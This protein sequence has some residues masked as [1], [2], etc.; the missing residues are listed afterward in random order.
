MRKLTAQLGFKIT[1]KFAIR[2]QPG[3]L[4]SFPCLELIGMSCLGQDA[5]P[6]HFRLRA[7]IHSAVH[8]GHWR[9]FYVRT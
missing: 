1:L 7:D 3:V 2:T 5:I 9:K 6:H 4:E 8:D